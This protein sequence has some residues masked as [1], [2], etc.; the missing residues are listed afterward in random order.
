LKARGL[1]TQMSLVESGSLPDMWR[2]HEQMTRDYGTPYGNYLAEL[3]G[4]KEIAPLLNGRIGYH[5]YWSDRVAG[6]LLEH[7]QRLAE[8]MKKYPQW[9]LWQTEYCIL[10]GPVGRG[11]PKR[12][13]GMNTALNIARVIHLDLAVAGASAWQWWTAFSPEDYKDGLIYTDWKKP[14][15]MESVYAS[16]TLWALG[17]YSRFVRPGMKRVEIAGDGHGIQGLLGSAY[18][19]EKGRSI[20]VVY[21]NMSAD[22]QQV[23]LGFETGWKLQSV[24][25]YVTSAKEGD[26]LKEYA[27]VKEV[28]GYR[29]PARSVMT[30]VAK[31]GAR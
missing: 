10:D 20:V 25:P 1:K 26:E 7:R 19:D 30:L 17:N 13:L 6:Q 11:G 12:D 2:T 9:K 4:D 29:I 24:Q 18:K 31:F 22:E 27:A 23:T 28:K 16:R 3:C 14:G 5:S 15:D 8:E 21:V